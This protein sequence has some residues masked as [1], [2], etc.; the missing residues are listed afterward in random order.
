M[1]KAVTNAK[2]TMYKAYIKEDVTNAPGELFNVCGNISKDYKEVQCFPQPD[3]FNPCEDVMGNWALRIAV[4]IVTIAALLGNMA[5]LLVLL[6]SRFR[7]T[8][9]KFLMCN[10]SV[11]DLCMGLYLL[12]IA[13]M[14]VRSI[15]DYFNY[16][17]DWQN[18]MGC[19]VAG[20]LT[21]FASERWYT[22]TYAIHLNKRL[23]LCTA[24]KIMVIFSDNGNITSYWSQQLC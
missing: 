20:F 7:M 14:D 18:G 6:S 15:G 24:T 19:R 12:L 17:I 3:P 9:P 4:W 22:I 8:V 21:V 23:K 2:V 16:A 13:I 5:V 10:L 11:A 1:I